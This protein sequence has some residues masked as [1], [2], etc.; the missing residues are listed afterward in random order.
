MAQTRYRIDTLIFAALA[1]RIIGANI[2]RIVVHDGSRR[3]IV[4]LTR[5]SLNGNTVN[6]AV[7]NTTL[8]NGELMQLKTFSRFHRAVCRNRSRYYSQREIAER[9]LRL[10]EHYC[11]VAT[12]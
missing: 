7:V 4:R 5:R 3:A 8:L 12:R 6:T 9:E 1:S 11:T 10:R 2:E